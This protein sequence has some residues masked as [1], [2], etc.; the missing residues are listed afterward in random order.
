MTELTDDAGIKMG[1]RTE[2]VEI[3]GDNI[4]KFFNENDANSYFL[5]N[6][7]RTDGNRKYSTKAEI[8]VEYKKAEASLTHGETVTKYEKFEDAYTSA[9]DGDTIK[10]LNDVTTSKGI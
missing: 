2:S 6:K 9:E 1:E 8:T 4:A 7:D 3:T 10:L 5:Y